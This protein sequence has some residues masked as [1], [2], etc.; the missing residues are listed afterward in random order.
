[1]PSVPK[2]PFPVNFI[3]NTEGLCDEAQAAIRSKDPS[4][5][6][7]YLQGPQ[8]RSA[9]PRPE[10]KPRPAPKPAAVPVRLFNPFSDAA[11]AE[12]PPL[13]NQYL[14][15]LIGWYREK[16]P[17]VPLKTSKTVWGKD[18]QGAWIRLNES[19]RDINLCIITRQRRCETGAKDLRDHIYSQRVELDR[20]TLTQLLIWHTEKTQMA[21][22]SN[23]HNVWLKR[24]N[25]D[26]GVRWDIASFTWDHIRKELQR[27]DVQEKLSA[28]SLE[29]F[30]VQ[31][32]EICQ[33]GLVMSGEY[34]GALKPGRF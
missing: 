1:M 4:G 15:Q 17:G 23:H 25:A 18:E 16:T 2:N 31:L 20:E 12:K 3:F 8:R 11:C 14:N 24:Q 22:A 34:A 19:W 10:P 29:D 9:S 26:G 21:L 7:H 33:S 27:P 30:K 5:R 6:S 13:T 28:T 32:R